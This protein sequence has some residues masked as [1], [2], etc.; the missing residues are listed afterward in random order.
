MEYGHI[1]EAVVDPGSGS[2]HPGKTSMGRHRGHMS[3]VTVSGD[4]G[5]VP[6]THKINIVVEGCKL[7]IG[8]DNTVYPFCNNTTGVIDLIT[9]KV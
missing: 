5:C 4:A 3:I 1:V 9:Y 7:S 8:S 6:V 2:F